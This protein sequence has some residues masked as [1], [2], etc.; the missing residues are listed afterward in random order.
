M[1]REIEIPQLHCYRCGNTWM[2]RARMVRICP[3]CKSPHWEEPKIGVPPGGGGLGVE[4]VL[5]AFR[6]R[7]ERLAR[8]YG[9]REVRVFGSVARGSATPESDVDFLV[10]FDRSLKTRSALRSI[11]LALE[12]EKLIG[13]HVDVATEDSLHWFI[14]PQVVAEAV[15]L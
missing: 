5:G 10:E 7:I 3:R 11:D 4:Q 1:V 8:R 14:Q 2:P 9:V 6:T 15:P 12:L 13:R